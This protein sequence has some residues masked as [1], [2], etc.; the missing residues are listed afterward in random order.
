MVQIS[1]LWGVYFNDVEESD[2]TIEGTQVPQATRN[3]GKNVRST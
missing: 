2:F 1:K 3:E